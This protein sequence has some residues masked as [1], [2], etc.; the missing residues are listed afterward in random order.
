M[1]FKKEFIFSLLFIPATFLLMHL[2]FG[3]E[4][5]HN[6]IIDAERVEPPY[7][8]GLYTL[9]FFIAFSFPFVIFF[10]NWIADRIKKGKLGLL[11]KF[12]LVWI[13]LLYPATFSNQLLYWYFIPVIPP[14]LI[15]GIKEMSKGIFDIF[16]I[17]VF[18]CMILIILSIP[19][20]A[21]FGIDKRFEDQRNVGLYLANKSNI[22]LLTGYSPGIIYYKFH[23]ENESH[24]F[25]IL[26]TQEHIDE[27]LEDILNHRLDQLEKTDYIKALYG[28]TLPKKYLFYGSFEKFD[29]IVIE[30]AFVKDKFKIDEIFSRNGYKIEKQIGIYTIYGHD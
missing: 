10:A 11:E 22:L 15:L 25:S 4:F 17:M 3:E 13:A 7:V 9:L 20:A 12:S 1:L 5:L 8:E 2:S 30:D 16:F 26:F 6:F 23:D 18:A 21:L 19:Y 24:G 14:I 29:H 28:P 27:E